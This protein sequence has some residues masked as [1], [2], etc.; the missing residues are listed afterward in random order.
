MCEV[1]AL[2][3]VCETICVLYPNVDTLVAHAS[4]KIKGLN[5]CERLMCIGEGRP[6]QF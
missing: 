1:H 5:L 3:M 2:H 6:S 4:V